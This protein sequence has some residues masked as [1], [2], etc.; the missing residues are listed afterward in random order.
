MNPIPILPIL[1]KAASVVMK[2]YPKAACSNMNGYPKA[3]EV[4]NFIDSSY[5]L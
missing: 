4:D 2:G 1:P 3:T 5:C